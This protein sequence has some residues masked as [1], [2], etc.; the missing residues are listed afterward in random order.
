MN[1]LNPAERGSKVFLNIGIY[2][3]IRH[4]MSISATVGTTKPSRGALL[5]NTTI[6]GLQA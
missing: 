3:S 2:Q 6:R 4:N 1:V 5:E